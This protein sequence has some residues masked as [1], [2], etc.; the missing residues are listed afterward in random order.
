MTH[1]VESSN[2][3]SLHGCAQ[4]LLVFLHEITTGRNSHV[5][6][7]ACASKNAHAVLKNGRKGDL[8]AVLSS[9]IIFLN[10]LADVHLAN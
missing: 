10:I 6:G 2:T 7:R 8:V 4:D 3:H 9:A 5:S 1:A